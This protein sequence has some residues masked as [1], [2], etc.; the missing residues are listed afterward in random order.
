MSQVK[1]KNAPACAELLYASTEHSPEMLYLARMFVPDPFIAMRIG[2]RSMG[3]FSQLEI[4]R[5]HK[6][7]AFTKIVSLEEC[8]IKASA[9]FPRMKITA[10]EVIAYLAETLGIKTFCVPESFP[11]GLAMRLAK[12]RVKVEPRS[13]PFFAEQMVKSAEEL[14]QLKK[15]NRVASAALACAEK[16]LTSASIVGRKLMLDGKPLTS[17]RVRMALEITA[18]EH[19]AQMECIVAGGDQACDPHE[20][21][22]GPYFF[23]RQSQ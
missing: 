21:G 15:A 19:G 22:S 5:A 3:V 2:K 1:S 11:T 16:M 23:E 8:R 13:E 17:E 20:Q 12:L 18:L 4:A 6:Q 10:A 9:R 7:S 14:L